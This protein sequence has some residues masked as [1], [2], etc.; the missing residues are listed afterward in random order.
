MKASSKLHT[1]G[2]APARGGTFTP[3]TF[4]VEDAAAQRSSDGGEGRLL[5]HVEEVPLFGYAGDGLDFFYQV[6][7]VDVVSGVITQDLG[8]KKSN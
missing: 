2:R 4:Y 6:V 3:H 8:R 7:C 1:A 5:R